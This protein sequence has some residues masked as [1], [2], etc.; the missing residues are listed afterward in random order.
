MKIVIKFISYFILFWWIGTSHILECRDP[1][2]AE[3][4]AQYSTNRSE[5]VEPD[6]VG[7]QDL[8]F[9]GVLTLQSREEAGR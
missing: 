4:H 5:N 6:I 2:S 7:V 1:L 3:F 9:S 8:P